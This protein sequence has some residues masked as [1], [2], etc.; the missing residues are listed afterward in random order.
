MCVCMCVN[1]CVCMCVCVLVCVYIHVC[2]YV[3]AF[4]RVYV[5]ICVWPCVSAHVHACVCECVCVCTFIYVCTHI[6][7]DLPSKNTPSLHFPGNTI[8]SIYVYLKVFDRYK[9]YIVA[10][11]TRCHLAVCLTAIQSII[12]NS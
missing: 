2:M 10:S 9:L 6:I 5:C 7:Y 3:C 8:Q 12:S 11:L 4:V 1:V